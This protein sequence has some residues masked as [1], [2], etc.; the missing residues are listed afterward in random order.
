MNVKKYMGEPAECLKN[1]RQE[2]KT[3]MTDEEKKL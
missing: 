1:E 2:H 3:R